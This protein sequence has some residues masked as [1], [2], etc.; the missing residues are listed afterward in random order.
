MIRNKNTRAYLC[1]SVI[2]ILLAS[3]MLSSCLTRVPV[4]SP[5][6]VGHW[7]FGDCDGKIVKDLS[8]VG[9]DGVITWGEPRKEK[10]T[11]SLELDG[12]D[13][14]VRIEP[15]EN[16]NLR[17]NITTVL[18]VKPTKLRNNTVLFGIPNANPNWTTPV[19]G[20]YVSGGHIIYGQYGDHRTRK[21]L[22]ETKSVLPLNR[23]TFLAA[24]SDGDTVRLYFDGK[25]DVELKQRAALV[26]NAQSSFNAV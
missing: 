20:M 18:W 14:H 8:C 9:N 16:F 4:R 15:K 7:T 24:T 6:L 22:V 5:D 10:G 2:A 26:F 11:T 21:V 23:W 25:L 12:L 3:V 13:G 19:F 1:I 17:T